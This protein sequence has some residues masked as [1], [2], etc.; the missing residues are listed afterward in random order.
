M[1][2]NEYI[3]KDGDVVV[4]IQVIQDCSFEELVAE[5]PTVCFDGTATN[6][7][8]FATSPSGTGDKVTTTAV[9]VAGL[10][11]YGRWTKVELSDGLVNLYL[12]R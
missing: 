12:G 10:V 3:P 7:N 8:T 2:I 9:F 1:E 5:D 4:A 6:N 11:L